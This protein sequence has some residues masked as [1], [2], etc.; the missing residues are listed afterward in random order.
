MHYSE[1]EMLGKRILV[2]ANLKAKKLV[3]FKV[4]KVLLAISLITL[5]IANELCYYIARIELY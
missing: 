5:V 1:E 3:G 2:V 4:R